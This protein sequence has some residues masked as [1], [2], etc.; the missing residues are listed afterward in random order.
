MEGPVLL[1]GARGLLG[2]EINS[3]FSSFLSKANFYPQDSSSLDL[4]D[5][6]TVLKTIKKINPSWII[7]ATAFANVDGAETERNKAQILNAEVPEQ[8]ADLASELK[9]RLVHFSTEYVF[10]GEGD[11]P[12]SETDAKLPVKPN[13]YAE[14][15]L[16]GENAVL[17]HPEHLVLRIQWLYG[18][19]KNRFV[20]IGN[21]DRFTPLVDQFGAPTWTGD[22]VTALSALMKQKAS[23]LFHFAYD[24]FASWFEVYEFVKSELNLPVQL[25]PTRSQDLGFPARR[26]LNGRLSNEKLKKQL[27]VK[28]LGSWKSSLRRFLQQVQI[29]QD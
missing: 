26:P 28:S 2:S 20:S 9:S 16:R 7:N 3:S 5:H 24:D 29:D 21:K 12:W 6:K 17:R 4:T 19:K 25:V 22:V 23:G 13:W 8:L 14:T 15:K 1:L 27:G 10:S 11:R 18:K